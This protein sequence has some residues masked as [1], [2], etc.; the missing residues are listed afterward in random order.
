LGIF[1]KLIFL[2]PFVLLKSD[3]Q[4]HSLKYVLIVNNKNIGHV[5]A[6][7]IKEANYIYYKIQSRAK[8]DIF[9]SF[10]ND[11]VMNTTYKDGAMTESFTERRV[12]EAI[13]DY[14]KIHFE[15]NIY[16][17]DYKKQKKYLKDYKLQYTVACL[18]FIEPKGLKT[19]F[20]ES[21]GQFLPIKEV[22]PKRYELTLPT[23]Q[24][25][26]YTFNDGI[27]AEADIYNAFTKV[28]F[29]LIENSTEVRKPEVV[30]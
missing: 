4:T 13:T 20:S 23:G 17:I 29:K 22:S 16:H 26:F 10:M 1:L 11:F 27:C 2:L 18:Y 6:S 5:F 28:S 14:C 15:N 3:S 19:V 9:I 12:N 21:Y 7:Q 30:K 8:V 25:N 24:K